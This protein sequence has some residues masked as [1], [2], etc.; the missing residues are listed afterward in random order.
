MGIKTFNIDD[1]NYDRFKELNTGN[2]SKI[3]NDFISNCVADGMA[4][5]QEVAKLEAELKGVEKQIRDL[6]TQSYRL[7]VLIQGKK[8][9]V[10]QLKNAKTKEELEID[11]WAEDIISDAKRDGTLTELTLKAESVRMTPHNFLVNQ[12]NEAK[13][14]K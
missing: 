12:W 7:S 6:K 1:E 10:E 11:Q 4:K 9:S 3:L 14:K 2:M 8:D 5:P 13:R